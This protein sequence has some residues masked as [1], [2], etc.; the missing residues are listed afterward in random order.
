M[1]YTR[2]LI[3]LLAAWLI[4]MG[5]S[6]VLYQ[7]DVIP[8]GSLLLTAAGIGSGLIAILGC[9]PGLFLDWRS[10]AQ[11]DPA[12]I[13]IS[14]SFGALIRI[15]GTVALAALCSYQLPAAKGQIAGTILVWYVYLTTVDVITLAVL[16]PGRDR[17][18]ITRSQN[19]KPSVQ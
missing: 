3:A 15:V 12:A 2:C 7:T 9:L 14:F 6:W 10:T 4:G 8:S 1:P 11:T 13:T 19:A 17:P 16:L 5:L 18:G